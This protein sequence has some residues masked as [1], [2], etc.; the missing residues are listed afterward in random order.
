VANRAE[1]GKE[2][3]PV[4][5]LESEERIF[6]SSSALPTDGV[7]ISVLIAPWGE[8][9]SSN[10]KFVVDSESADL[11]LASFEEHGTDL[12]ID[13][14]HQSLGGVYASPS[15]QAPAAG[16]IR[17]LRVVLPDEEGESQ[18]GL[19][20]DVEWTE[21]AQAKLAAREY[22][23]LSPVVI[24]R[25][26][27]RRVVALHSAALTN[28]PAIMGMKPIVNREESGAESGIGLSGAGES[29]GGLSTTVS[30]Q[31]LDT[32][33]HGLGLGADS[34]AEVVL[35]AAADRLVGLTDEVCQRDARERVD[36][37]MRSGKLA[38]AQ[39]AWALS[40]ALKDPTG[41]DEWASSAPTVVMMG[42]TEGPEGVNGHVVGD[43]SA[44]MSSARAEFSSHPE[45][46][47]LTSESAWISE[48]L[49]EA[50]ISE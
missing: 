12:P 10:G 27:D 49:R 35:H 24:V 48:A 7:P 34:D 11:V 9:E 37:A 40:L 25:K 18:A 46:S 29:E 28:K 20:A 50:G 14:E 36:E 30:K 15:G 38:P 3:V 8:V 16:W 5:E 45:L 31:A 39:R 47:L 32:L 1:K 33:R 2:T 41:F 42:L 43:R 23:Y 17:A 26:K 13:Y 44:V 4:K 19:F 21:S 6:I 22:R